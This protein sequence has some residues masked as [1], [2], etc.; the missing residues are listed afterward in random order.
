MKTA[1]L[2]LCAEFAATFA[3]T[4]L[5]TAK[6]RQNSIRLSRTNRLASFDSREAPEIVANQSAIHFSVSR[7]YSANLAVNHKNH[8]PVSPYKD[9]CREFSKGTSLHSQMLTK[10]ARRLSRTN[11]QTTY[12]SAEP[13][14]IVANQSAIHFSVSLNLLLILHRPIFIQCMVAQMTSKNNGF[15]T[16]IVLNND[17]LFSHQLR[18][19]SCVVII[20]SI[21]TR[22]KLSVVK[23][24]PD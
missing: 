14:G 2:S 20:P 8:F 23:F 5:Y 13:S 19:S 10:T 17:N 22:L 18:F 9:S 24:R 7:N 15:I 1:C 4:K 21:V 11:R 3:E 6:S 16:F 12:E